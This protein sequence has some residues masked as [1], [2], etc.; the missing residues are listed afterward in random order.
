MRVCYVTH[1]PNMYGA[2]KSLLDLL[3][4][5]NRSEIEPFVLLNGNGPLVE[6]L[7]KRNIKY[8]IILYSPAT[9][10][11]AFIK[12]AGKYV[13]NSFLPYHIALRRIKEFFLEEKIELVHNNSYL[14]GIGMHAAYELGIPYICHIREFV[15][16]G[17]HRKFYHDE[18][19]RMLLEKATCRIA[20]SEAVKKR[21]KRYTTK[22]IL[23]LYDG[24][25]IS[26]YKLPLKKAFEKDTVR[27]IIAG[28]ISPQ[29]GQLEAVQAVDQLEKKKSLNVE[30]LVVGSRGDKDYTHK[31]VDYI[32]CNNVNCVKFVDYT[33]DLRV[34][35]E[36]CDIGLSCSKYEA[37]GRVT[38][39]NML[40]SLLIVSSNDTAAKE[41]INDKETGLLY[42]MG[43]YESLSQVLLD[44]INDA[45]NSNILIESA[46]NDAMKFDHVLYADKIVSIYKSI[47]GND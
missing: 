23:V 4:G 37:L 27:I 12:N 1:L 9:N 22:D 20:I 10:S 13:L 28:R 14:V 46:Y 18:L 38:I 45:K 24:I 34:I 30:L 2:S 47:L 15:E 17:F 39:E 41:L 29:K 21:Y 7:K 36:S 44:A 19:Q 26:D 8:K 42:E 16:E 35:R 31:I 11:D 33:N 32:S 25:K 40:S 3:D 6:E 43:S 5:L